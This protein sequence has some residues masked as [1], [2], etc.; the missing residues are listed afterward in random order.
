MEMEE[1]IQYIIP[2]FAL[3]AL[4]GGWMGMQLL[5]RKMKVKNH[6]D[7]PS[8]CCGACGDKASCTSDPS[9]A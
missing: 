1:I 5:A 8:G 9:K 4:A 6:I 7:N 3:A 2:I